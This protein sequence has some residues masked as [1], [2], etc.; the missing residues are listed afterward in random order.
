MWLKPTPIHK[1][2]VFYVSVMNHDLVVDVLH[3]QVDVVIN[4]RHQCLLL[5][6][7]ASQSQL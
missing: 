3:C 2:P 4:V 6:V 7:D 5:T 1:V